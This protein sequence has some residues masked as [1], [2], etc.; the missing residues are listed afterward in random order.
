MNNKF[1]SNGSTFNLGIINIK[2]R[3]HLVLTILF[4]KCSIRYNFEPM[5]HVKCSIQRLSTEADRPD[6]PVNF[7]I[8]LATSLLCC[9]SSTDFW[10]ISSNGG[11]LKTALSALK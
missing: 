11:G 10:R 8:L 4:A 1:Y 9:S 2:S 3:H 6:I 5:F 7:I